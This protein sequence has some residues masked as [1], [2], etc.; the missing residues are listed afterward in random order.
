MK[1]NVFLGFSA[2]LLLV[3]AFSSCSKK[4]IK[5]K[6]TQAEEETIILPTIEV[7]GSTETIT[8]EASIRGRDFESEKTLAN[9]YFEFDKYS[10]SEEAR[11]ILMKNAELMKTKKEA[12]FLIEGHCD[13]RGTIEYN[14]SLGQKRA[15]EVRDYYARLGVPESQLGTI[16]YGEE[17]PVC[18]ESTEE[19]WAKNRRV[20]TKIRQ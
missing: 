16:S 13:E 19:C 2:L 17:N 6:S 15:R 4:N 12:T 7:E 8:M 14:L 18:A 20:V 5:K 11:K 1:R 9:I 10:L 3:L